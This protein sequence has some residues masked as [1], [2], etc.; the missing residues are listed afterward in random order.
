MAWSRIWRQSASEM[1]FKPAFADRIMLTKALPRCRAA[2]IALKIIQHEQAVTR[3]HV[4]P[5]AGVNL[6]SR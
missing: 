3:F 1:F 5:K 4:L 6:Q 2:L